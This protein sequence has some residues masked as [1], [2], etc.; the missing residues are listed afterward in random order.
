MIL[1]KDSFKIQFIQDVLNVLVHEF[2]KNLHVL[3]E[4][5]YVL[6]ISNPMLKY[7]KTS[8]YTLITNYWFFKI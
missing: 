6:R 3:M 1:S 2:F 4:T 7:K 8:W 5:Y